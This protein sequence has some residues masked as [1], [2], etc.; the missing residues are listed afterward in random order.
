MSMNSRR[1]HQETAEDA[2]QRPESWHDI[3]WRSVNSSVV[4]LRKRI[5]LATRNN[6][7]E[8]KVVVGSF[9]TYNV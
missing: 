7:K 9:K 1:P 5:F 3:N 2:I 8:L 6:L 4:K